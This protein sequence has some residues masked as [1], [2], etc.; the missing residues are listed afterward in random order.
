[1]VYTIR[2]EK[3]RDKKNWVC[4]KDSIPLCPGS[5]ILTFIK[6]DTHKHIQ[7]THPTNKD[8]GV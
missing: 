7:Q 4:G 5:T 8:G 6:L 2:L 3:Y 1:M